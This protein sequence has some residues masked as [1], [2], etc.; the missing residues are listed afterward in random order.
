MKINLFTGASGFLGQ[1]I[2]PLLA[3]Q[4]VVIT[5]I[6]L[7]KSDDLKIDLSKEIPELRANFDTVIHAATK[8]RSAS[9]TVAEK[10]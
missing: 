2:T 5:S 1:N 8:I 3:Q 9:K 4:G 7:M 10:Q 6:G